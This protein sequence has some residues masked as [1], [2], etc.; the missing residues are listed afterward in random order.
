M[1]LWLLIALVLT[2][3]Q[4]LTVIAV[5]VRAQQLHYSFWL[6]SLVWL[7]VTSLQITIGYY[8]GKWVKVRFAGSKFENWL[9]KYVRKLEAL[10]DQRGEKV[11]LIF[12]AYLVLPFVPAFVAPWLGISFMSAFFFTLLGDLLWYAATWGYTLGAFQI[13]SRVKEGL[14]IVIV[15]AFVIFLVSQFTKSKKA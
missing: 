3:Q 15:L 4:G 8:L 6:I 7:V 5:L 2:F 11:A 14:L 13:I 1:S 12:M 10:I 9:Q